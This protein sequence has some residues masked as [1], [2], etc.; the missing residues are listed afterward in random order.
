[1]ELTDIC[2]IETWE[3]LENDIFD[4]FNFQGSVFDPAGIRITQVKN[5]NNPL[6]PAIKAEE[7]GQTFICS[8]AHA[9]MTAM[10]KDLKETVVEECDAGITKLVVPIF[11]GEEFVGIAGGCGMKAAGSEVDTFAI[12]KLAGMDESRLEELAADV[13]SMADGTVEAVADFIRE[14]LGRILETRYQQ[15][16]SK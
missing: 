7:K 4:K 2:P 16:L 1:M 14:E 11:Y 13:P 6:C 10:A 12:S 5:F 8:A 9:N 15:T 3:A